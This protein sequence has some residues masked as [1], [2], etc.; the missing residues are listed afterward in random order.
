MEGQ[1]T[2]DAIARQHAV[3]DTSCTRPPLNVQSSST[4]SS[5]L[6]L[7]PDSS[8]WIGSIKYQPAQTTQPA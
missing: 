7:E 2:L 1:S 5:L 4:P 3:R 6:K 8:V